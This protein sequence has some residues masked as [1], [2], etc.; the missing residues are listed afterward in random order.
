MAETP[1]K[2]A[3]TIKLDFKNQTLVNNSREAKALFLLFAG[4]GNAVWLFEMLPSDERRAAFKTKAM[5]AVRLALE[6]GFENLWFLEN[7]ADFDAIRNDPDYRKMLE[8]LKVK[9]KAIVP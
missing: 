7:D 2:H 6:N 3:A 5:D 4:L 8:P 1:L 9:Q